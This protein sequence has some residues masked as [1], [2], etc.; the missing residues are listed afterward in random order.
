MQGMSCCSK[1][2]YVPMHAVNKEEK[3]NPCLSAKVSD[4]FYYIHGSVYK[5]TCDHKSTYF[6]Y[7]NFI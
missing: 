3:N 5:H 4:L 2:R 6:L 1:E 7:W